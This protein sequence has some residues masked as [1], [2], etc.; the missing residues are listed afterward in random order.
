MRCIL[1]WLRVSLLKGVKV[2]QSC[3]TLCDSMDY[4]LH[5]ILQ[6]RILQWVVFPFS[7]GSSQPRDWIQVS[8]V[9]GRFFTS[10]ATRGAQ[11]YWGGLPVPSPAVLLNPG[12]KPGSPALQADSLPTELSG[13]PSWLSYE[14]YILKLHINLRS[15][16]LALCYETENVGEK[17][18]DLKLYKKNIK[19]KLHVMVG[20]VKDMVFPVVTCCCESLNKEDCRM[21][22]NWCLQ[23]VVLEKTSESPLDSKEIKPVSLK[24]NQPSLNSAQSGHSTLYFQEE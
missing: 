5:G 10:W 14:I 22:E 24:G 9:A 15:Y 13:K 4:T 23:N 2:A 20:I 16:L 8:R 19:Q 7:R 18:D 6:A 1:Q 21:P 17:W 11:E 12:S 3:P